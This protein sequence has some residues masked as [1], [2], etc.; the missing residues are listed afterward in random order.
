MGEAPEPLTP[1]ECDLRGFQ[2]LQLDVEILPKSQLAN[3]ADAEAFRAAVLLW[4]EAWKQVPAAS[5]ADNELDLRAIVGLQRD[6]DLWEKIKADALRGFVKCS[7][8][9]LYHKVLAEKANSAWKKRLEYRKRGKAGAKAKG[10]R[11][12]DD[13]Q[14]HAEAAAQAQAKRS[15][16][17]LE[18]EGR[19]KKVKVEDTYSKP[20]GINS[21]SGDANCGKPA[22]VFDIEYFLEDRDRERMRKEFSGWDKQY[23]FKEFNRWIAEKVPPDRPIP[24]FFAF[25]RKHTGGRPAER[26]VG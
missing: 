2:N 25:C 21:N 24:A 10:K 7:D 4:C 19:S 12:P 26:L 8:G 5:L 14:A 6:G 16:G 1:A 18:G 3:Y 13:S 11:V 23:L 17:K 15:S 20:I 22:R 9:R